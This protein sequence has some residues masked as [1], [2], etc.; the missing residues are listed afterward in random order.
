MTTDAPG[1]PGG[2]PE[3]FLTGA[4]GFVGRQ[5]LNSLLAANYRVRA[6]IRDGSAPLQTRPGLTAVPGDVRRAGELVP[7]IEGCEYLIHVAALYSFSPAERSKLHAVNVLGTAGII[8]AARLAGVRRAVVTSSSATVGPARGGRLATEEDWAVEGNGGSR[9]HRSKVEQERVA[10]AAQVPTVVLL[11]TAPMGPGD[12]KP[13]PTGKMLIDFLRGRIFASLGG[14]LNVVAVED[15]A[16]AHVA[17]LERG[18]PNER[19]LIGGENVTLA[20][21]WSRL[22]EICGRRA[23]SRRIPY[24]LALAFGWGD[25]VRCRIAGYGG[26]NVAP[27][28]PLEGVH[29]AQ[30]RMW[31]DDRKARAELG[32]HPTSVTDALARAVA[33]YREH[34]YVE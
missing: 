24:R 34:R 30:H 15:V 32:H 20:E 23:P 7:S 19:Y 14:G 26:R 27:L 16:A 22:G 11:P 9:Y 1:S 10:L 13:T 31:V 2:G 17:A 33:W 3:V 21:L 5:V 12:W 29:M 8:E 4:T 18:R 6:L 28:V 25:E